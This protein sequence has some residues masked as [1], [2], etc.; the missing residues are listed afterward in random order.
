MEQFKIS[1][2]FN[3]LFLIK[4]A[5]AQ[6]RIL[7]YERNRLYRFCRKLLKIEIIENENFEIQKK[8]FE[9]SKKI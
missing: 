3:Y 2:K 6:F 5:G 7:W 8:K 9:N 4:L 1:K